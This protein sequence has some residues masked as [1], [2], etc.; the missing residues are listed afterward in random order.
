MHTSI[1]GY[2]GGAAFLNQ[3]LN[4]V[5]GAGGAAGAPRADGLVDSGQ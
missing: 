2:R 1:G 5:C 4:R 3:S